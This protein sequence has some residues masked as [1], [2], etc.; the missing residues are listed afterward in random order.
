METSTSNIIAERQ[1]FIRLFLM[2]APAA[3]I[4][5]IA[6]NHTAMGAMI[7]FLTGLVVCV[8]SPIYGLPIIIIG[9][10]LNNIDFIFGLHF[11][12]ILIAGCSAG[13]MMHATLGDNKLRFDVS[14]FLIAFLFT[15]QEVGRGLMAGDGRLD[16]LA[17]LLTILLFLGLLRASG[18]GMTLQRHFPFGETRVLVYLVG[19]V[20]ILLVLATLSMMSTREFQLSRAGELGLAIGETE[21]SPR[22]LSN[23][24]GIVLVTC[25]TAVISMP[26]HMRDKLIWGAM[27]TAAF[28]GMVYTGSRMPVFAAGFALLVALLAQF[29]FLGRTLRANNLIWL[30]GGAMLAVM[31][32]VLL[33]AH[34]PGILPFAEGAVDFRLFRAP[35]LESN[36]R[37]DMWA[38]YFA[39]AS[40]QQ[41]LLGTGIGAF[42]N[43][44]SL[45]VGT[46]ITFGLVGLLALGLFIIRLSTE[47]FRIRSTV[48]VSTL[49]YTLL[50]LSSSSD[51][52]KSYFWVLC[53]V[54][55]TFICVAKRE[56][57]IENVRLSERTL[58]CR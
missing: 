56:S 45:Y 24:L 6:V 36:T 43:P 30:M 50:A 16:R 11:G 57:A 9:A 14:I 47:A 2:L 54:I 46:L 58:P 17:A 55:I 22:S 1:F 41:L 52:D 8:R 10:A 37:L 18:P 13:T 48:A 32:L 35:V 5:I 39:D 4:T 12:W 53:S 19:G 34:G 15:L 26:A 25:L 7:G 27:G 44:H 33:E 42:G 20:G 49:A 31:G 29:T 3:A 38:A 23:I 40:I 21:S 51:I 28:V